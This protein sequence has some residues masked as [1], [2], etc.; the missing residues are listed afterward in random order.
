M[1][2]LMSIQEPIKSYYY[3]HTN[4]DTAFEFRIKLISD[5]IKLKKNECFWRQLVLSILKALPHNLPRQYYDYETAKLIYNWI[6]ARVPFRKDSFQ[7]ETIQYPEITLEYGGDCDC[8]VV[9]ACVCLLNGGV[10][11]TLVVSKQDSRHFDHIAIY[12]PSINKVFDLTY[13][14]GFPM[15]LYQL[16]EP[17][18]LE[19]NLNSETMGRCY[20]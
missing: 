15:E 12:L 2:V 4:E 18:V 7:V 13:P 9:L 16:N 3:H 11:C 17:A 14:G 20:G 5:V 10:P 6:R 19:V 1:I 8:Q